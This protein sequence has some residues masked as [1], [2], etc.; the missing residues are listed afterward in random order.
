MKKVGYQGI[1]GT[2]SEIGVL[3]YFK[4]ELYQSVNYHN[5][6]DLVTAVANEEI[7]YALLPIE[8]ST[9][10]LI[11]RSYDLL[12]LY[13]VYAVG[14]IY[15]DIELH[16]LV[17][18]NCEFK[19]IK[20][21]YSHV[22]PLGQ[23]KNFFVNNDFLK[24]VVYQDTA[25][26]AKYVSENN[27]NSSAAIASELAAEYYNLKIV[28]HDINDEQNNTTRFIC[29]GKKPI[30]NQSDLIS[31]YITVSHS[32]GSLNQ[33]LMVLANNDINMLKLQSRPIKDRLFEY[34]FYIDIEANINNS[35]IMDVLNEMRN[36]CLEFKIL[37]SY[38][39]EKI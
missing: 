20:N 3:K 24:P 9:T 39:R 27:D 19:D 14:E 4:D 38:Q 15:I 5:F 36:N 11:Y 32:S 7:D 33:I 8:N 12:P 23:C 17:K 21:V 13:D 25:A 37:G 30:Y 28:K 26:S 34:C 10:G 31:L 18:Q 1:N 6:T 22:E 2:F 29:I 35:A 16:L